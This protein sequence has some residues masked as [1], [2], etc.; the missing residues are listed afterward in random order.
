MASQLLREDVTL[1]ASAINDATAY[2]LI[3]VPTDINYAVLLTVTIANKNSTQ[4]RT[5]TMCITRTTGS[6]VQLLPSI[7][8]DPHQVLTNK[9]E[10]NVISLLPGDQVKFYQGQASDDLDIS[11]SY[12]VVTND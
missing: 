9:P 2:T 6:T 10:L 3:T 5:V 12:V 7:E 4:L 11:V 8:V 1:P